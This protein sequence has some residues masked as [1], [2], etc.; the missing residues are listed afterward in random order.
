MVKEER[1][2]ATEP[3]A[4]VSLSGAGQRDP[5]IPLEEGVYCMNG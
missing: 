2:F 4:E 3:T 1:C 5:N